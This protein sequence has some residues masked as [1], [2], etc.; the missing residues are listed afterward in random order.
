VK[1]LPAAC[2]RFA[3]ASGLLLAAPLRALDF[4]PQET[5][6][7]L[8]GVRIPVLMFSD[9]AG[10]IRYQPPG[11]WN[12][13][14]E[15]ATF[16]LY[17]PKATGAFMKILLLGHPPGMLEITAMPSA[18][19]VKWSQTYL[20]A[21]AN[22][23]KLL[24]EN[25]S[26]FM[27]SRKPSR[28]FVFDYKSSGRRY[29]TSVAVLDWSDHEHLAVVITAL[30]TDFKTVHDNGTSS[31]FSWSLRKSETAPANPTPAPS[32]ATEAAP[33]PVAPGPT[34]IRAVNP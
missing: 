33:A 21:D 10:K 19:L 32:P 9:P 34:P 11:G 12:Y 17:P 3:L 24:A 5:W 8:E 7:L 22:D 30:A 25:P 29:Q 15:G 23:V 18:D 27:L 1:S 2:L 28:E 31:M 6:R 14:G 16:A 26:P 20:A 13:S 4:T